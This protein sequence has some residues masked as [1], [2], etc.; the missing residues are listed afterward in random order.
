MKTWKLFL[1]TFVAATPIFSCQKVGIATTT[2]G[3][4]DT[5]AVFSAT[6]AGTAWTADSVSA[7]LIY[8]GQIP[9]KVITMTGWSGSKLVTLT[10]QDSAFTS[11]TDSSLTVKE[12]TTTGWFP[13]TV[14]Q[15]AVDTTLRNGD[16][17][18]VPQLNTETGNATVTSTSATGK[19]VTGTF[20]FTGIIFKI[21]SAN[22]KTIDTVSI[23][24]G[25]FKN[26]HYTYVNKP[27]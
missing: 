3:T 12:Y 9:Y 19:T 5:S 11:S 8:N 10:L 2:T 14:L 20:S 21:D 18:W 1:W 23:T 24:N 13:G 17:A 15:Y 4:S 7:V 16:T 26:V 27:S 6:I 25:V 22:N